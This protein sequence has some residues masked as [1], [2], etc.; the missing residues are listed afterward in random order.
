MTFLTLLLLALWSYRSGAEFSGFGMFLLLILIAA[1]W[2]LEILTIYFTSD[3][4][5]LKFLTYSEKVTGIIGGSV[6]FTLISQYTNND[7][8]RRRWVQAVLVGL[9]VFLVVMAT[10]PSLR[11]LTIEEF[12]VHQ[13]GVPFTF[14]AFDRGPLYFF[15]LNLNYAITTVGLIILVRFILQTRRTAWPRILF[16]MAS[17]VFVSILNFLSISGRV[18]LPGFNYASFGALPT[19]L[20]TMVAIYQFQLLDI[21]P[22][23][24]NTLVESLNDAV[25][26]VDERRCVVDYNQKAASMRSSL[27]DE[28]G[29]LLAAVWPALASQVDFDVSTRHTTQLTLRI[30]GQRRYYSLLISPV[31]KSTDHELSG[32]SLLLRD[33]TELETSRQQLREQNQRLDQVASTISHDL[34]NPLN[35]A[36]GY[37]L[38]LEEQVDGEA[39]ETVEEIDHSHERMSAI[40]DD[41]LLLARQDST[42]DRSELNLADVV[43][44]AWDNVDTAGA[45]LHVDVDRHLRADRTKLLR[46]FENLFRNA[47]EHG[48][49]AEIDAAEPAEAGAGVTVT[50]TGLDDGFAVADD[51]PGIPSEDRDDVFEYGYTTSDSGTGFG[52]AI[53]QRL[54]EVHGWTIELDPSS[55]GAR[56]IVSGVKPVEPARSDGGRTGEQMGTS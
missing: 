2:Q 47:I 35:V 33:V 15:A 46:V 13:S 32:Y 52:L 10:V 51:G 3:T 43:R 24:R 55:D 48:S 41:V 16:L 9:P 14:A 5:L 26:V 45:T 34:R 6:Y 11:R 22:V 54:L 27:P 28:E 38:A 49:D 8:H 17:A 19:A 12:T 40:I 36:Q 23:A 39:L 50:V 20:A 56:F 29:E 25:I 53:V 42:V 37:L 4:A 7:Y 44:D 31:R 1:F 21:I 30:D 18:P